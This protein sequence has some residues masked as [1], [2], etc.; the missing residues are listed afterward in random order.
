MFI[1]KEDITVA[2][3]KFCTSEEFLGF[4]TACNVTPLHKTW[5]WYYAL[6][7]TQEFRTE[8]VL[9]QFNQNS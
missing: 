9:K 5:I 8:Q 2:E 7:I 1:N 4:F 6:N 3:N